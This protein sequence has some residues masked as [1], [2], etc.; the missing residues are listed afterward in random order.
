MN[1]IHLV[2]SS[3]SR[4]FQTTLERVDNKPKGSKEIIS[5]N[6]KHYKISGSEN[7][8]HYANLTK[9]LQDICWVEFESIKE[10]EE[11]FN[12]GTD[13]S[14]LEH[15]FSLSNGSMS[16]KMEDIGKLTL[17][18]D[19]KV[20]LILDQ[21]GQDRAQLQSCRRSVQQSLGHQ[22][23]PEISRQLCFGIKNLMKKMF[24]EGVEHLKQQGLEPPTKYCIVGLGSIAREEA[25]P[26]PDFDHIIVVEHKTQAAV[27][28]FL[29]L[30][31]YVADRVYRLGE[32]LEGNKPGL[33]FC[34]GDL[35]PPHQSYETRYSIT[36]TFRGRID[37][38]V[39]PIAGPTKIQLKDVRDG[40][41]F[42]GSDLDL[43]ETYKQT[44]FPI[45][46]VQQSNDI[47]HQVYTDLQSRVNS[48]RPGQFSSPAPITAIKLPALL[49]IKED[50]CRLPA[51][52]IGALSVYYGISAPTTLGRLEVLKKEGYL[53]QDLATRLETVMT[54]LIKWRIQV[55][56]A[57][58]QEFEYVA[59]SPTALALF[60]NELPERIHNLNISIA[61]LEAETALKEN[62]II[63]A[64][65]QLEFL[66][67]CRNVILN[68][69]RSKTSAFSE[70][71]QIALQDVVIPILRELYERVNR[72]LL[73]EEKKIDPSVFK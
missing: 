36:P 45:D 64:K 57:H 48:L 30:N 54:L 9:R 26:F 19:P 8:S 69:I 53:D 47:Q 39:E 17:F 61:Q 38:L 41:A 72:S 46:P 12:Q 66:Q 32:S 43:Y 11:K 44:V 10:F 24:D 58:G 31:Q 37:L 71:D 6:G 63:H 21:M 13:L 1:N 67:D 56:S 42:C 51:G 70:S 23:P 3:N 65:G 27:E 55:Q 15:Y 33:R 5:I 50:L 68:S 29:R 2:L 14:I 35:N 52:T 22:S 34:W 59:T 25:G 7:N 18:R 62:T 28:Y 60:E 20:D 16:P 40:V 49:N 73:P 4:I